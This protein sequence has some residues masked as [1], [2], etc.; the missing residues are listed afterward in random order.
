MYMY[1]WLQNVYNT[2]SVCACMYMYM[3]ISVDIEII[4]RKVETA[5]L[6][7][8][9]NKEYLFC[10][11]YL[12]PWPEKQKLRKITLFY[13]H[14]CFQRF[15][16]KYQFPNVFEDTSMHIVLGI[17]THMYCIKMYYHDYVIVMGRRPYL[18]KIYCVNVIVIGRRPYGNKILC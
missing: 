2:A 16:K 11:K 10:S 13:S 1:Q 6:D 14:Q 7:L 18:N 3:N 8:F 17:R 4:V 12:K 15:I 5:N 9:H